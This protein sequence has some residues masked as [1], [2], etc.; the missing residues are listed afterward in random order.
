MQYLA[1]SLELAH[2]AKAADLEQASRAELAMWRWRVP[3]LKML[4]PHADEVLAVGF[5]PDGKKIVTGC[6][7]KIVQVWDATTGRPLGESLQVTS[8]H[9]P[10][11]PEMFLPATGGL[12]NLRPTQ[13]KYADAIAAVAFSSDGLTVAAGTGDPFYKGKTNLVEKGDLVRKPIRLG[14]DLEPISRGIGSFSNRGIRYGPMFTQNSMPTTLWETATGKVRHRPVLSRPTW[15]IAFDPDGR[16]LVTGEGR[17][18]QDHLGLAGG[19]GLNS[20]FGNRSPFGPVVRQ[21]NEPEA[22]VWN[23]AD[24][25]LLHVLLHK[26]AV[27]A[28][29]FSPDGR[30]ILTGSADQTARLWDAGTGRP[31]GKPMVHD[32][33]VLV[34]TFSPDGQL[35]LTCSQKAATEGAVHLW[36][37][38]TL[39]PIGQPWMHSRPVLAAAFSPDGSM[40]VTGT[41]DA[42]SNQGEGQLWS[43]VAGKRLGQSIPHPGP[44]HSLAWSPDGRLMVT[45]CSDK[46]A[47]IWEVTPGPAVVRTSQHENVLAYSPDGRLALIG[48]SS[49]DG[50]RC[51]QV[52]LCDTATCQPLFPLIQNGQASG[53]AAFSS[54]GRRVVL[55]LKEKEGS[56]LQAFDTTNS[57]LGSQPIRL[58]EGLTL[59]ALAVSPDG[60]TILTGT[61]VPYAK[62]GEATLWNAKTS[63]PLQ[64]LSY[65]E[66]VLSVAFAP[67]GRKLATGCGM[68][69]T[70][71]GE[72]RLYDASTGKLVHTHT[73]KHNGPVRVVVFSPDG[74]TL[75]TASD[76]RTARL[77]D[78]GSSQQRWEV[79]HT[80]PVRSLAFSANGNLLLTGSD[81]QTARLWSATTGKQVGEALKHSG[82]VRA[83]AVNDDGQLLATGSD[84]QTVKLWDAATG[85]YLGETLTH[86]GPVLSVAFSGDGRTLFT[87]AAR[88]T[89]TRKQKV[90][91]AWEVFSGL[92][93]NDSGYVWAL[94]ASLP[95]DPNVVKLFTQ[96]LTGLEFDA[97]GQVRPLDAD[98]WQKQSE[99]L[100]KRGN[101]L[102]AGE[103]SRE[104][105]RREARKAEQAGQWFTVL[106][107][108]ERLD[109]SEPASEELDARRGQA[110]VLSNRCDRAIP[111]LTKA[112]ELHPQE[113]VLRYFRGRAYYAL[114]QEDKALADLT[115]AIKSPWAFQEENNAW[116]ARFF[117]GLTYYRQGEMDK[118]IPEFTKVL[119]I[120]PDHGPAWHGR[121]MAYA[122]LGQWDRAIAD[123]TA[124]LQKP[125]A[126]MN[127]WFDI[128]LVQLQMRDATRY[129][130]TC[131]NALKQ[132]EQT[133]DSAQL[134]SLVWTCCLA[135]GELISA[136]LNSPLARLAMVQDPNNYVYAR[137]LGASYYRAGKYS[138]CSEVLTTGM[139]DRKQ[140]SPSAW[141]FLA[142]ANHHLKNREEAKKWLDRAR[143]CVEQAR[144]KKEGSDEN[145]LSWQKLPW[146]ERVAL[147]V[148]LQE[149]EELLNGTKAN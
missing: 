78:V 60:Q 17:F 32:G 7:N 63:E 6:A 74:L 90:G 71:Q 58:G 25:R 137:A 27:L 129:R 133:E 83:V 116:V 14:P 59:E 148:L 86:Q 92:G 143:E 8:S 126:P 97:A 146:S 30:R 49:P 131:A 57:K 113:G 16:V 73:L 107:H 79:A 96:L 40:V 18:Q 29:A 72:A 139:K 5:S 3:A 20:G 70:T 77:W 13:A 12:G 22:H 1:H 93:W 136:E 81:D 134:T 112:L 36:R 100:G 62:K 111:A 80:A 54:D 128:A 34:A 114:G 87:R 140:P 141:L 47:R 120:K 108:L 75:A 82:P 33:L 35:I 66:A 101:L 28:V 95:D 142:M 48:S 132:F 117:R 99:H 37:A 98:T 94:P 102:P 24:G 53:K 76:D 149:A 56:T 9:A 85:R 38:D 106:W 44:V 10:G 52:S 67:D 61:S 42:S 39:Q 103:V 45:G 23:V 43:V 89:S 105:H 21:G 144:R 64:K 110:Y 41:G 26:N 125:N 91:D 50:H 123:F 51:E 104:W 19:F 130:Q 11:G 55:E 4:L 138:E 88:R 109:D 2:Q 68:P 31:I 115:E 127:T 69:S 119:S 121:G 46:I 147:T 118:V 84:D 15:A 122:E 65:E 124:A 145:T 135:P